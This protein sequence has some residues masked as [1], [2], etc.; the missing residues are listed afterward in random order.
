[1]KIVLASKAAR[2]NWLS[3]RAPARS[4]DKKSRTIWN[5]RKLKLWRGW[6]DEEFVAGCARGSVYL[7]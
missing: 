7:T 4:A 6:L 1:M 3:G 2:E 5:P